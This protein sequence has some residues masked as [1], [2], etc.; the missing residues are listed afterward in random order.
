MGRVRHELPPAP[1]PADPD[2]RAPP[3]LTIPP[4]ERC[5]FRFARPAAALSSTNAFSR[6]APAGMVKGTFIAERNVGSTG[7]R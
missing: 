5:P 2:P 3:T 1:A 4:T 7:Q 6:S